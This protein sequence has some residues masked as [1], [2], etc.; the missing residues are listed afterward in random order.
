MPI[1]ELLSD[2]TIQF[3]IRFAPFS[4]MAAADLQYLAE[5]V[6][7]AYYPVG[8]VIVD[9]D[10]GPDGRLYVI[11]RGFVRSE[12]SAR[13]EAVVLGPGECFPLAA[14]SEAYCTGRFVAT[15]D[16]FS[17]ELP[18][19]HVE[20]LRLRSAPFREYIATALAAVLKESLSSAHLGFLR[21]TVNQGNLLEPL[22]GL[23]HRDAVACT[24]DTPI[25][26]S[27]ARMSRAEVGTIVVVDE[28]RQP[29]GIFTLTDLME[30]VVLP[31]RP[32]DDPVASVMTPA[33]A[34]LEDHASAQDAIA[35]MASRGFHQLLV[36]RNGALR[37]VI[38]ERDLFALQ[39]VSIRG[40]LQ[41][42]R[43]ATD[44][45]ELRS[46]AR[47]IASLTDNL[48][49]QG[50]AAEHLTRVITALNDG[51][52]QRVLELLQAEFTLGSIP[53]CWLALGSEGRCEQTMV[54]D[55]DNAM[56]FD[57]PD[58]QAEEVRQRLLPFAKAVNQALGDLG[59]PLCRG[60][61]MA[62]NPACC[63]STSEWRARF[64]DWMREP[65]AL[66]LLNANIFFDLR[67]LF[68][69]ADLA[70]ELR[71]WV[72]DRAGDQRLFLGLL[73][74]NALQSEPPLGLIR[75]FRTDVADFPG[76]VD[77]KAQGTRLF[78]DAARVFALEFSIAE[79]HTA[80]RLRLGMRRVN[81]PERDLAGLIQSFEFL[82]LLRFR[83]QSGSLSA[84][85]AEHAD[86][87]QHADNNRID[88]YALSDPDQRLLKEAFRQARN[89]QM[90]LKQSI[91]R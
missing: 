9:A 22:S 46:A 21:R 70:E 79:T 62:S 57:S 91:V 52:S 87:A 73:A 45:A 49:A 8:A 48:I 26:E 29:V 43:A 65:T 51:V 32:L 28:A 55:Q 69:A 24:A 89:L 19:E 33:P 53:W 41:Q 30:R 37:G 27:L 20:K 66:A 90:L 88:P 60:N 42:V 12:T 23:V 74:E 58:G 80:Q 38:S 83:A 31:Q 16:V 11:H 72:L 47:D 63:L 39:R 13:S 5:H 50:V 6:R 10:A 77:L 85:H 71:T 81:L 61:I 75:A 82:Q 68:G 44:V 1:P 40:V 86:H 76:R 59:F 78:V 36:T 84:G 67:P 18:G 2:A 56:I 3:L 54:S 35:L 4:H 14:P 34:S 15:E 17:F 64:A 7:L 25:R